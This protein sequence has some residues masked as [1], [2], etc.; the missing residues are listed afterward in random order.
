M[1]K[2]AVFLATSA[3]LVACATSGVAQAKPTPEERLAKALEGRQAGEPVS[4]IPLWDT[5]DQ[6]VIE[7][8]AI[9]YGTGSV[10]YVNRPTNAYNLNEDDILVLKTSLT[11]LCSVDKLDLRDRTTGFF[12]G[13]VSLG[14]FVPY[15]RVETAEKSN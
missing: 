4:C 15:R 9:I 8:T 5:R 1:N 2:A 3:A 7:K 14:K 10:I 11:Q 6:Q 13:F 12:T